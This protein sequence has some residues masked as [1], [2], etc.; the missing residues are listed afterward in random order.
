MIRHINPRRFAT[1]SESLY[2]VCVPGVTTRDLCAWVHSLP[3]MRSVKAV[4]LHVGINDCP[5]GQISQKN[6][7]ELIALLKK[8]FPN[9]SLSFSSI[10][11]AMG[12]HSL[13]N[14]IAPSN[15]NPFKVCQDTH[16]T[17]IDNEHAFTAPSGA[18][19]LVLYQDLTHPSKQGTVRLA[20]N[21]AQGFG[22][23][24]HDSISQN[25]QH[26]AT[27]IGKDVEMKRG[28]FPVAVDTIMKILDSDTPLPPLETV[29]L[30]HP[31]ITSLH[32]LHLKQNVPLPF[33]I[34]SL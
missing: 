10:I 17:Y 11:P 6:W 29:L 24:E 14:S 13:N 27:V 1:H 5:A 30:H 21:L 26:G 4:T 28:N 2:K 31:A 32:Y 25:Q 18:P 15:R 8:V 9:A 19:R 22:I 3:I 12:S 23:W 34:S 7:Y 16:V 20:G 33:S